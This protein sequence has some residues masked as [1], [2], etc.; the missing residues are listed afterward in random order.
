MDRARSRPTYTRV[1]AQCKPA[2]LRTSDKNKIVL[3]SF[4]LIEGVNVIA[5]PV[6]VKAALTALAVINFRLTKDWPPNLHENVRAGKFRPYTILLKEHDHA[7]EP[8]SHV[9]KT[10]SSENTR[11]LQLSKDRGLGSQKT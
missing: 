2:S 11:A 3:R 7:F 1:R 5:F 10:I 9:A 4:R 6:I 8:A